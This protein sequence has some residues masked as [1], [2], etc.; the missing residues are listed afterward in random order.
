[1]K[2]HIATILL[3][4]SLFVACSSERMDLEVDSHPLAQQIWPPAS[5]GPSTAV[6]SYLGLYNNAGANQ[7]WQLYKSSADGACFG[8]LIKN[9][10]DIANGNAVELDIWGSSGGDAMY[11][12]GVGESQHVWCANYGAYIDM[13]G[14]FESTSSQVTLHGI[15]GNDY[16]WCGN[17]VNGGCNVQGGDGNDEIHHSGWGG[18]VYAGPG[19]DKMFNTRSGAVAHFGAE[20]DDCIDSTPTLTTCDMGSGANARRSGSSAC[21]STPTS[22]FVGCGTW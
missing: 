17:Q 14:N 6:W 10:P 2:K 12:L 11:M 8:I 3:A 16:L 13:T 9:A 15:D 5:W 4:V 19:R 20:G 22:T 18:T 21:L 1:M 7:I